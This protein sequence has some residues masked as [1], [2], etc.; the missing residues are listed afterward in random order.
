MTYA[1]VN[2]SDPT[3]ARWRCG[4]VYPP[5]TPGRYA[6]RWGR[7]ALIRA[8]LQGGCHPHIC[9]DEGVVVGFGAVDED[10]AAQE[11]LEPPTLS[12]ED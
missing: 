3:R 7:A 9:A 8:S 11:G 10:M 5:G 1:T 4:C 6:C 12:S 2:A